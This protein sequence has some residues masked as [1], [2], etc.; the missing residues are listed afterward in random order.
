MIFLYITC[1]YKKPYKT[2][3]WFSPA[4]MSI[5]PVPWAL[6]PDFLSSLEPIKY[7]SDA[8]H[9]SSP[10]KFWARTEVM[11]HSHFFDLPG[12]WKQYGYQSKETWD[13]FSLLQCLDVPLKHQNI[14]GTKVI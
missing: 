12:D 3:V 4:A 8:F 7:L 5:S 2:E 1:G 14:R 10:G 6:P 13:W 9:C 11:Q